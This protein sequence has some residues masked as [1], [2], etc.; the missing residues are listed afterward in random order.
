MLKCI[1]EQL[2]GAVRGAELSLLAT[3]QRQSQHRI[4]LTNLAHSEDT[5]A[6]CPPEWGFLSKCHTTTCNPQEGGNYSGMCHYTV[7]RGASGPISTSKPDA[8]AE[9]RSASHEV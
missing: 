4:L 3:T 8:D 5:A 1:Y 2:R 7:G 6:S 9:G